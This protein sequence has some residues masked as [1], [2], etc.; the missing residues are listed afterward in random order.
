[1]HENVVDIFNLGDDAMKTMPFLASLES[2]SMDDGAGRG[3]IIPITHSLPSTVGNL[4][5]TVQTKAQGSVAGNS[6]VKDRWVIQ[7]VTLEGVAVVDRAAILGAKDDDDLYDVVE[8]ATS[9]CTLAMRKRIAVQLPQAGWGTVGGVISGITST[10]IDLPISVANRVDIGQ[11]LVAS[12][13]SPPQALRSNTVSRVTGI[14][15]GTTTATLTLSVDPTSLSWA[16]GDV[17]Y[18]NTDTDSVVGTPSTARLSIT[19][20]GEWV[21][22][23]APG[24]TTLFGINRQ[25]NPATGGLRFS[26]SG[27]DHA[28]AFIHAANHLFV[29]GQTRSDAA[30]CSGYDY[31]ILCADKDAT[32]SVEISI[33]KYNIGFEGVTV[34]TMFGRMPIIPDATLQQ[35]QAW[36]GPWKNKKYAPFLVHND[37]LINIDDLD[38][39]TM[40]RLATATS[41]EMRMYFRGNLAWPAPGKFLTLHTLPSA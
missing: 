7:H 17:V 20:A 15:L 16:N 4:F 38:G 1:M 22:S 9:D 6:S 40:L 23:T 25:N 27:F 36:M 26:A 11:D 35:G 21:P 18:F 24:A 37:D 12:L 10:T 3:Y 31:A 2:K 39:N 28:Q 5:A 33:G 14:T 19:G 13:P 30:Y 8:R 32:K 34:E 41:Y 29:H